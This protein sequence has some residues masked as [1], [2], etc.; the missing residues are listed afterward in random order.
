MEFDQISIATEKPGIMFCS[1]TLKLRYNSLFLSSNSVMRWKVYKIYVLLY[2]DWPYI[3]GFERKCSFA[4]IIYARNFSWLK[5]A[6]RYAVAN[7][8]TPHIGFIIFDF[9]TVPTLHIHIRFILRSF[10]LAYHHIEGHSNT[11]LRYLNWNSIAVD[12]KAPKWIYLP[13]LLHSC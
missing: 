6:T 8:R 3:N 10:Y 5:V 2:Q 1:N 4:K 7:R 11:P 12:R 9:V 13:Y